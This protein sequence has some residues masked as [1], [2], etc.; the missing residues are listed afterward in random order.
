MGHVWTA[1]PRQ[2]LI[3][4]VMTIAVGMQSCVW[5]VGAAILHDCW[6]WCGSRGGSWSNS[7]ARH[8]W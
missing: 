5:P 3:W 2:V 8:P 4:R 6:P 1:P 7:W